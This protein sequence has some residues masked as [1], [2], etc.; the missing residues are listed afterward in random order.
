M[1]FQAH[2]LPK[3]ECRGQLQCCGEYGSGPGQAK[4]GGSGF[5]LIHLAYVVKIRKFIHF[6][7]GPALTPA[8]QHWPIAMQYNDFAN[9]SNKQLLKSKFLQLFSIK[10][11]PDTVAV[12]IGPTFLVQDLKLK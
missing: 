10:L 5:E 12:H 8:P 2:D 3:Y 6:D 9:R 11:I 4:C 7:A 1:S